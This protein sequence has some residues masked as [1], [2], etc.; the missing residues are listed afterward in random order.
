MRATGMKAVSLIISLMAGGG[1]AAAGPA[2]REAPGD[3][4]EERS[5]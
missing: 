3:H 4:G 2:R 1:L 5:L